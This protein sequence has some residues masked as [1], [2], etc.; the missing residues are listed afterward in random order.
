MS[1]IDLFRTKPSRITVVPKKKCF[2]SI[3]LEFS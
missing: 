3:L 2:V 1:L